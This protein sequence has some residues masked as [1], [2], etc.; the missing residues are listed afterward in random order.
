LAFN[1]GADKLEIKLEAPELDPQALPEI[2]QLAPDPAAKFK[3]VTLAYTGSLTGALAARGPALRPALPELDPHRG[4][5]VAASDRLELEGDL[6]NA[7]IAAGAGQWL[8]LNGRVR[9]AAD[10]FS[11]RN[12]TL[13]LGRTGTETLQQFVLPRVLVR[14]SDPR[15]NLRQ[16][17]VANDL[18]L[19]IAGELTCSAPVS[20]EQLDALL[21]ALKNIAPN[22]PLVAAPNWQSVPKLTVAGSLSIPSASLGNAAVGAINL[23]NF[24]FKNLRLTCPTIS[25]GTLGGKL[26]LESA[27]FDFS[28]TAVKNEAGAESKGL[29]HEEQIVYADGNLA[30]FIG[31]GNPTPSR[32]ALGGRLDALGSLA[33]IDFGPVDRLSWGGV[34]KFTARQVTL[35]APSENLAGAYTPP[36]PW[37]EYFKRHGQA[38]A[39]KLAKASM[40]DGIE[41]LNLSMPADIAASARVADGLFACLEL[42][43]AKSCGVENPAAEFEP[44]TPTARIDKGLAVVEPF[45]L[46]GKGASLGLDLEVREL[47]INLADQTFVGDMF[48]NPTALPADAQQRLAFAKWPAPAKQ[49]YLAALHSGKIALRI[50]GS[51]LAPVAKFPWAET[52][53]AVREALFGTDAIGDAASLAKAREHLFRVWGRDDASLAVAAA[54]ADRMGAGVPGMKEAV[55][56]RETIVDNADKLPPKLAELAAAPTRDTSYPGIPPLEAL[57]VFLFAEEPPPPP[58]VP[59]LP[60]PANVPNNTPTTAKTLKAGTVG[61]VEEKRDVPPTSPKPET[62]P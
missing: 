26:R 34:L 62:K 30:Q 48:V 4:G 42:Y 38:R 32:Y 17:L 33:G 15:F 13:T 51:L 31:G 56:R 1:P 5:L 61:K 6:E 3:R 23:K 53:A 25:A 12:F 60:T 49:H 37:M 7:R 39:E 47:K 29:R 57:K 27:E 22:A 8:A 20:G 11:A 18:P 28:K 41:P 19:D 50:G 16:A 21:S 2:W 46:K 55:L 9:L 44:F 14:S 10:E 43:L 52:R 35:S 36:L 58:P 59:P 45:T 54:L 24:A 40:Q